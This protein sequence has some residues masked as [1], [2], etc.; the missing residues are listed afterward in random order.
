MATTNE[1]VI[2]PSF[3]KKGG[4]SYNSITSTPSDSFAVC[5]MVPDR[6]IPVIFVPGVMGTNLGD[7]PDKGKAQKP[8]WLLNSD[9]GMAWD[10]GTTKAP[11]RKVKLRPEVTQVYRDGKLPEGTIQTKDELQRRGW[12]EVGFGSYSEILVWLENTLNDFDNPQP[13]ARVALINAALEGAQKVDQI[14]REEI[15]LTYK[16][17]LPVHAVGY[18]WLDSNA[19][20]AQ[21]LA[22]KIDEFINFYKK[23]NLKCEKVIVVTHSMG[24]L[25][26]RHCSENLGMRDKILGIVHGVMPAIGAAAVY[27][28]M[29][30][31]TENPDK[32]TWK[33]AAGGA[34]SEVLGGN[35]AEMTA[36]L[37]S[38]PGPLQLLPSIEYGMQW[39]KFSDGAK[40]LSTL[41]LPK[42]DP[43]SEIY[44]V[45]GKWWSLCA[46]QLIDPRDIGVNKN[47]QTVERDWD[48]FKKI[49]LEK[50]KPFLEID[51]K[52]KYH[53]HTYAFIGIDEAKAAYGQVTWAYQSR[54]GYSDEPIPPN[55]LD[56]DW[57]LGKGEGTEFLL[58]S[59]TRTIYPNGPKGKAVQV[60]NLLPVEISK[61]EEGGDGTVPSRSGR[62]VREHAKGYFELLRVGH[63]PAY[64]NINAHAQRAALY[65]IIKIAQR[66]KDVV[67]MAY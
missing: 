37:S 32:G 3:D 11:E 33:S 21:R 5:Y 13:G 35:S 50:V 61:A 58:R 46:D 24:G 56:L 7:I 64:K 23:Q 18:N 14:T 43:Y 60:P 27:R 12:G 44:T 55:I 9:G 28:R 41:S 45:R 38:A 51:I 40:D 22:T 16:Y 10:W 1:R 67:G 42:A 52:S 59:T 36:V 47:V 8:I 19:K 57:Q 26:G 17:R 65:G 4:V 31:G 49:I 39:L 2:Q 63:E 20:S 15:G 30:A 29:K 48:A 66:I 53:P 34:A 6:V 25:V 54:A 62:A